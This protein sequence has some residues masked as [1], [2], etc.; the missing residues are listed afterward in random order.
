MKAIRGVI[1]LLG[2][3]FLIGV[4]FCFG[5]KCGMIARKYPEPFEPKIHSIAETQQELCD[6]GHPVK[7]DNDWGPETEQAYCDYMAARLWPK[8]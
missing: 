7:V 3:I 8:E 1:Q 6:A 4:T 2:M 5:L